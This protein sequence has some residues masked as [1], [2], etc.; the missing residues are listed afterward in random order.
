M[1]M[2]FHSAAVITPLHD[3]PDDASPSSE[4]TRLGQIHLQAHIAAHTQPHREKLF[5]FT[6]GD[7]VEASSGKSALELCWETLE[8]VQFLKRR[9][10]LYDRPR[11]IYDPCREQIEL[12]G[13]FYYF[14]IRAAG[15]AGGDVAASKFMD[16]PRNDRRVRDYYLAEHRCPNYLVESFGYISPEAFCRLFNERGRNYSAEAKVRFIE[17]WS[18]ELRRPTAPFAQTYPKDVESFL[19]ALAHKMGLS[20][21]WRLATKQPVVYRSKAKVITDYSSQTPIKVPFGPLEQWVVE[22]GRPTDLNISEL[23]E[24]TTTKRT[25]VSLEEYA[26]R[27]KDKLG[28]GDGLGKLTTFCPHRGAYVTQ[29][30]RC[31]FTES[32]GAKP[33]VAESTTDYV[34]RAEDYRTKDRTLTEDAL[35]RKKSADLYW[36]FC[37]AFE[38]KKKYAATLR[39]A[40][41]EELV[42]TIPHDDL[43]TLIGNAENKELLTAPLPKVFEMFYST[44]HPNKGKRH[45]VRHGVADVSFVRQQDLNLATE[46]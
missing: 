20:D 10:A 4:G 40:V 13:K 33:C 21:N 6:V 16:D 23:L 44:E 37:V 32:K 1:L 17:H 28:H 26:A 2:V 14:L 7:D 39:E 11:S 18:D 41:A 45:Y 24:I 43:K 8:R 31:P 30:H 38:F 29:D 35:K 36:K 34:K 42:S 22:S 19:N 15:I 12:S 5:S 27:H 25:E 9:I 46:L 3:P